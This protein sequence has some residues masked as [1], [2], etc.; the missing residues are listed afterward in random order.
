MKQITNRFFSFVF[1]NFA[2]LVFHSVHSVTV[3]GV[4]ALQ[5]E[6]QAR[7]LL[8]HET[9]MCGTDHHNVRRNHEQILQILSRN[10]HKA[11]TEYYSDYDLSTL[12]LFYYHDPGHEWLP[13]PP[14]PTNLTKSTI[15]PPNVCDQAGVFLSGPG[16]RRAVTSAEEV[17]RLVSKGDRTRATG[18]TDCNERSSRSHAILSF[19]VESQRVSSA[20]EGPGSVG[21]SVGGRVGARGVKAGGGVRLGKLHLVDLAGR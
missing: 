5:F 12:S 20:L 19:H 16:L 6:K 9:R 2:S 13:L 8:S 14:I 10:S 15:L 1:V 18:A 3:S 4:R 21:G 11:L 17:L 7:C